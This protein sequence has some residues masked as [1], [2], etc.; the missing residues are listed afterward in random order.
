M[1][2]PCGTPISAAP[3]VRGRQ[4]PSVGEGVALV[5]SCHRLLILVEDALEAAV[6]GGVVRGVVLPAFPDD[7][8]PGGDADGVRVIAFS[9]P[10]FGVKVR[11]PGVVVPRVA[12]EVTKRISKF[13][14]GSPTETDCLDLAGLPGGGATPAR[15]ASELAVG[16]LP[17]AS[18]ISASS[19]A[20]LGPIP[21]GADAHEVPPTTCSI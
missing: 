18:P 21:S 14:V 11:R 5:S 13:F 3:Q 15:Q 7:G 6:F 9:G 4:E 19:R 10:S 17:R 16:N 20:W 12:G 8:G 2:G 1:A